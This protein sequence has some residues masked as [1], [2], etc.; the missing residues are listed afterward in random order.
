MKNQ[1][2]SRDTNRATLAAVLFAATLAGN[3]QAQSSV[4]VSGTMD[5]SVK[6]VENGDMVR[7]LLGQDGLNYSQLVFRGRE[8]LGGGLWAGFALQAGVN[9]DT[10]TANAKFF[11]R[12]STVSLGGN[13]GELRLGRDLNPSSW[14]TAI[15]DPFGATGVG[16]FL[17]VVSV[18]GSGATTLLRTD[19][20]VDY[21]LPSGLGGLYGQAMVAAGEGVIGN[22]YRG[23]RLGF[24]KG[25]YD[26]AAAVA[27]TQGI[28]D[29]K[30]KVFNAGGS[31]DFQVV[32]VLAQYYGG[33]YDTR[34]QGVSLIGA[35]VPIGQWEIK[36]AYTSADASGGATDANDARQLA[37]GFV[38]NLS[39]RTATYGTYSHVSN[40]GAARFST[41]F[42]TPSP[43][44]P[45][46]R[47]N[48]VEF[49]LRHFF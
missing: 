2:D 37:A 1:L 29:I 15:F 20:A 11:N 14:N 43:A 22:K 28:G 4:T 35:I 12:R 13:W 7:K 18:L 10:G 49:G 21:L 33:R 38:Y 24:T 30:Y 31:Y 34:K 39:K 6:R 3:A 36:A 5:L 27:Q 41:D 40:K 42:T 17:N 8:D 9:A 19:N 46:F 48:G 45:G 47:S 26:F 25:P 32:K 44:T 16:N 23:L